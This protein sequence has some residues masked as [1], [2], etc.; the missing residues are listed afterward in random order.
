MFK[1]PLSDLKTSGTSPAVQPL[2]I[3]TDVPAPL[4]SS[5]R[6]KLK[7]R[8]LHS[9]RIPVDTPTTAAEGGDGDGSDIGAMLVPEGIRSAKMQTYLDE[10]GVCLPHNSSVTFLTALVSTI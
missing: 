5:D 8:V 2:T 1:K 3:L 7:A 6:K 9:F 10:P 4:R